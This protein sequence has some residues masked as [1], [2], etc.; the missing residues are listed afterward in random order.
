MRNPT[1][2]TA[3]L[4]GQAKQRLA[5]LVFVWANLAML[6]CA[7]AMGG[8]GSMHGDAHGTTAEAH[9]AHHAHAIG[10][11]GDA[12]EPDCCD[13]GDANVAAHSPSVDKTPDSGLTIAAFDADLR[14]AA[15][16]GRLHTTTDP[17]ERSSGS[18]RLHVINC[19]YLD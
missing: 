9:H 13:L 3:P 14:A 17:P 7:M 5:A 6:P 2:A 4:N 15:V 10:G 12:A 11:G 8:D 19:V 18:S 16:S 1:A